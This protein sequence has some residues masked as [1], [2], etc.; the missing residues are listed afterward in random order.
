MTCS[1]AVNIVEAIA[2]GDLQVNDEIRSHFESCPR[3]AAALASARR[4]ESLLQARPKVQPPARFTETVLSRIRNEKWQTEERVDRIFNVAIVVAVLLVVGSILALTNVGVVLGCSRL[5]LGTDGVGRRS[6]RRHGRSD[7]SHLHRRG[8]SPHVRARHV[9][10]GRSAD[11]LV[12]SASGLMVAT[13]PRFSRRLSKM[14]AT[15]RNSRRL[16]ATATAHHTSITS[17]VSIGLVKERRHDQEDDHG[18]CARSRDDENAEQIGGGVRVAA[19]AD[20]VEIDGLRER[21]RTARQ[22]PAPRARR[23]QQ[24]PAAALSHSASDPPGKRPPPASMTTVAGAAARIP[25]PSAF[26]ASSSRVSSGDR[27]ASVRPARSTANWFME[28]GRIA[29]QGDDTAERRQAQ[30]PRE[31]R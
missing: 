6:R 15:T 17:G 21:S 18:R 10:V 12:G 26:P 29:K 1:D 19:L 22:L 16:S 28:N 25:F 13:I 8:R 2:A 23:S 27:S 4:V 3:C 9:V 7:V 20:T 14:A 31:I 30:A 11:F 24:M 5:A